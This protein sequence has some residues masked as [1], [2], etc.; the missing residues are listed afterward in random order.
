MRAIFNSLVIKIEE[1]LSARNTRNF[2]IF[3]KW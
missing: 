1:P 3:D 2:L